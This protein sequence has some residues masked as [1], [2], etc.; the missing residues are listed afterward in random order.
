MIVN[1]ARSY[2]QKKEFFING[3]DYS[4]AI[5]TRAYDFSVKHYLKEFVRA[6]VFEYKIDYKNNDG[7][8]LLAYFYI[9]KIY[10]IK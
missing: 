2:K 8:I 3:I 6:I 1:L 7:K 9:I 10:F 5:A 4:R